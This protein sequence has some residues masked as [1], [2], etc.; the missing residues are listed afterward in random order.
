MG[1]LDEDV[2]VEE[3]NLVPSIPVAFG[4]SASGFGSFSSVK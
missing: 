3:D 1:L 4:S 2:V